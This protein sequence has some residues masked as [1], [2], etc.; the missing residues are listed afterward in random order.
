M[1]NVG[2][3]VDDLKGAIAF[4]VELGFEVEGEMTVEGEWVDRIVGIDGVKNDI[5]M[6][7]APD[8]H[9][10]LELM[11]F[12]SPGAI[13]SKMKP[14][15]NTLGI[16]RIMFAVT[17][18]DDVLAR[19]ERRGAE[20]L[21]DVVPFVD[22]NGAG[23]RL[24]YLRGHE[25]IVIALAEPMGGKPANDAVKSEKSTLIRMDNVLIVVEDP[26]AAKS[27]FIELGLGLE[28]EMTVEG[29]PVEKLIGLEDVRAT[30]S[31]MRM[32]DGH[33]GIELDKFHSPNPTRIESVDAPVNTLGIRR[34]MFA[35]ADIDDTVA[36][37]RAGGA[38]LVG[39]V[40]QY[41]DAYRLCYIRGPEGIVIGLAEPLGRLK[42]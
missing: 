38:E 40:V 24:C 4:F 3:V 18:L 30:L 25:G 19:L 28:G 12:R 29:P 11:K 5:A 39:E 23:Y 41:E 6:M 32:P 33:G 13:A 35:V 26:E 36:R 37:L 10:K 31:V 8:G 15:V 9:G 1:D 22:N 17:N 16:R 34:I 27:F 7:R 14:E 20:R 2:I 42:V 21:G